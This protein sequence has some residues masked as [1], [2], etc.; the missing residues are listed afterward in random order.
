MWSKVTNHLHFV[1]TFCLILLWSM[2]RP[3]HK[4]RTNGRTFSGVFSIEGCWWWLIRALTRSNA[5]IFE[6][7][8]GSPQ[9]PCKQDSWII[10]SHLNFS[11]VR[12]LLKIG[13][14]RSGEDQ[15]WQYLVSLGLLA[16]AT[17]MDLNTCSLLWCWR[18]WFA[19][20]LGRGW[21]TLAFLDG[22]LGHC[23]RRENAMW[24]AQTRM[25]TRTRGG[26]QAYN[27]S[28]RR[29]SRSDDGAWT[30]PAASARSRAGRLVVETWPGWW[31]SRGW[32]DEP[33][34]GEG[35]HL[36]QR[37]RH[38]R[39]RAAVKA[40]VTAGERG[41]GDVGARLK[42]W[43]LSWWKSFEKKTNTTR[44]GLESQMDNCCMA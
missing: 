36:S 4:F 40:P 32:L 26:C 43:L 35:R 5:A 41:P 7:G 20:F 10:S 38:R 22:C 31:P 24:V 30:S 39:R 37:Q 21:R 44:P 27:L 19:G 12:A 42:S 15:R 33:S 18:G 28:T 23:A 2:F 6:L 16:T 34:L 29:P 9:V 8:V 11:V 14:T 17:I 25:R 1:E 3:T 13:A